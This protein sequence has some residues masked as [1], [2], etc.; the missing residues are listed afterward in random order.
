[1]L[2]ALSF[3]SGDSSNGGPAA[4]GARRV[5]EDNEEMLKRWRPAA[6]G[7]LRDVDGNY[8]GGR[9]PASWVTTRTERGLRHPRGRRVECHLEAP[10]QP[11]IFT[12]FIN[13]LVH[14]SLIPQT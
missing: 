12:S 4:A 9:P 8:W 14:L 6:A 5:A 3:Q 10:E 13:F 7:L 11:A 1:M 2:G